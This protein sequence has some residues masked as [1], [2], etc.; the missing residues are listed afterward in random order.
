MANEQNPKVWLYH[1]RVEALGGIGEATEQ[2]PAERM[3]DSSSNY[4]LFR[5][6]TQ[7]GSIPKN[8]VLRWWATDNPGVGSGHKPE[9][10][11]FHN[12]GI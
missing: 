10:E 7:V 4:E 12:I 8:K 6:D 11:S 2:I 5:G 3:D 1:F 9:E